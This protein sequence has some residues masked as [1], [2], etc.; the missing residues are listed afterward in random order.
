[1]PLSGCRIGPVT[2]D[3]HAYL[4]IGQAGQ[5]QRVAKALR[6]GVRMDRVASAGPAS[7]KVDTVG[8]RMPTVSG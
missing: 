8:I 3:T 7:G 2:D 1:L 4:G 6:D 5:G